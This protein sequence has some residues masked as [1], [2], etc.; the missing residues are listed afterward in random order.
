MKTV[1]GHTF[2]ETLLGPGSVVIDI[3]CRGFGFAR[4]CSELGC[5][6][7]AIDADPA[8]ENPMIPGVDYVNAAVV[9]DSYGLQTIP[10]FRDE[11]DEGYN[12]LRGTL[13]KAVSVPALKIGILLQLARADLSSQYN[14]VDLIKFDCEGAEYKIFEE[15]VNIP[16]KQLSIEFHDFLGMCPKDPVEFH[17]DLKTKLAGYYNVEGYK[18]QRT[19][20]PPYDLHYIDVWCGPKG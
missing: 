17:T 8:I 20:W 18:P 5:K 6:V 11:G 2:D 1:D 12:T 4:Y 19:P 10:L 15:M 13:G 7:I 14:N 3:G 9:A 16:A